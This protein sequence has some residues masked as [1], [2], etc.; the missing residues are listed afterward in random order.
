MVASFAR[1]VTAAAANKH[2]TWH[3]QFAVCNVIFNFCVSCVWL[4]TYFSIYLEMTN[5]ISLL[6]FPGSAAGAAALKSGEAV[7]ST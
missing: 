1:V 4:E 5:L 6:L 2:E 7:P 3:K